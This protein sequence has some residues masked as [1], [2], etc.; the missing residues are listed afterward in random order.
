[1]VY[2]FP[3][4]TPSDNTFRPENHVSKEEISA[5]QR[6]Q[7]EFPFLISPGWQKAANWQDRNDP[8]RRQFLPHP[9]EW[10]N[11][12]N[13]VSDPLNEQENQAAPG[14]LIKYSGRALLLASST[15]PVHCRYCFRRH[16]TQQAPTSMTDW[17]PALMQIR[18]RQDLKEVIL[19]G[20]DPLMLPEALLLE[21][22]AALSDIPHIRRIRLHSRALVARPER[23]TG[24]IIAGLT[25]MR[26]NAIIVA[27]INHVREITHAAA[28]TLT[29]LARIGM[30]VLSQSVLLRGVN[31]R[32]QTLAELC[33]RVVDLGVM[34]YYLH[35]LDPVAGSAHFMVPEPEALTLMKELRANLPGYAVPRLARE[36]PNEPA[37]RVLAG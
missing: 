37:K 36:V 13:F 18:A 8:L 34:P 35:L 27:H 29:G 31:D 19:S 15:C 26:P 9:D 7:G 2:T 25:D 24:R 16:N 14:L 20:G 6:A 4:K 32:W 1:M 12:P 17:Q 33:E 30:P 22:L 10:R 5:I 3:S 21:M 23:V 11:A 28:V